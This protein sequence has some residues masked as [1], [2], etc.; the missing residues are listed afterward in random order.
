M[1]QGEN[2]EAADGGFCANNPTLYAITEAVQALKQE[3]ANLRVISIGVGTYGEPSRW[4]APSW[5]LMKLPSMRL[6]EKTLNINGGSME[7]LRVLL[8]KDVP[9]IRISDTFAKREM[10]TD[11]TERNLQKLEMLY[12][13]GRE[14]FRPREKELREFLL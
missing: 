10:A 2:V 5:W 8:F 14:S 6:V 7:Q 11:L 13:H 3:R 1:S 12:Q 9:T 4:F